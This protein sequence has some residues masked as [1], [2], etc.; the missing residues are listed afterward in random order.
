MQ[1]CHDDVGLLGVERSLYLLKD[2]FCWAHMSLDIENHIKN[3]ERYM[4]LKPS[5][6]RLS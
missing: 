4:C 6:K 3:C 1:V 5:L 2:K